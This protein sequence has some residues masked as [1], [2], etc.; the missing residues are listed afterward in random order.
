MKKNKGKMF[1]FSASNNIIVETT[2]DKIYIHNG[3]QTYD[4]REANPEETAIYSMQYGKI[5]YIKDKDFEEIL[6][7]NY[8]NRNKRICRMVS[9]GHKDDKFTKFKIKLSRFFSRKKGKK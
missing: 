7:G 5:V 9:I 3:P 2:V 1:L 4:Y 8:N 6:L